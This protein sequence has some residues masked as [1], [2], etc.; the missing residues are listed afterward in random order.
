MAPAVAARADG[1][2]RYALTGKV[3]SVNEAGKAITGRPD[4]VKGLMLAMTM[5]QRGLAEQGGV[6]RAGKI[7]G[8]DGQSSSKRGS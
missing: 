7:P 4:E 3:L 8:L 2:E 5:W 6:V 1:V